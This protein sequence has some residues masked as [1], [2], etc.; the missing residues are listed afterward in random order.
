[1]NFLDAVDNMINGKKLIR[2]GWAGYYLAILSNQNYIWNIPN[3]NDKPVINVA[4]YTPSVSDI[5]AN[6]W[7]VKT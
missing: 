3:G 2:Q 1:M 6:D 7:I 4:L 5:S